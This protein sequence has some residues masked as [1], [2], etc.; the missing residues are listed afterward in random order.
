MCHNKVEL[1]LFSTAAFWSRT[2][3]SRILH[4]CGFDHTVF[5]LACSTTAVLVP[6]FSVLRFQW[7]RRGLAVQDAG[8]TSSSQAHLRLFRLH[9]VTK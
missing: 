5:S 1:G 9:A 7:T 2:V 3:Q 4:P 6:R 8:S